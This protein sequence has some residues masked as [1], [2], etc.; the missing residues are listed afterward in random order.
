MDQ[1]IANHLYIH[2]DNWNSGTSEEA[3]AEIAP[4]SVQTFKA[5]VRMMPIP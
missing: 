1:S 2:N 4:V 5:T 3:N